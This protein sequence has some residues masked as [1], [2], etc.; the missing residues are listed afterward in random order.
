MMTGLKDGI[1]A[2]KDKVFSKVKS[3]ANGAMDTIK[4]VLGIHS[5]STVFR[6]IG[7]YTI[8]GLVNGITTMGKMVG[9][10]AETVGN[11]AIDGMNKSIDKVANMLSTDIDAEP[12]I[13]PV[14][15]LSEIQNGVG[16]MNGMFNNQSVG[17]NANLN[18]ISNM[19]RNR[20][21]TNNEMLSA[22]KDLG[23]SLDNAG[24]TN[25]YNVNGINYSGDSDVQSAIETLVRAVTVEGRV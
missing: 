11:L 7:I 17:V 2:A 8:Q 5:P 20:M 19:S 25:N 16:K 15:D 10:A 24:T 1:E 4:K 6:K 22:I 18:A 14:L 13:T 21:N 12:T 23:K 9:R 3:I